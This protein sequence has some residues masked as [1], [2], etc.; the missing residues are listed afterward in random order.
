M[1]QDSHGDNLTSISHNP[2]WGC[3]PPSLVLMTSELGTWPLQ[4]ATAAYC[5]P[6]SSHV[7]SVLLGQ[8]STTPA[9]KEKLVLSE[10][11]LGC[12]VHA[13]VV[14]TRAQQS[15]AWLDTCSTCPHSLATSLPC[16]ESKLVSV[17]WTLSS[18]SVRSWA[19][20]EKQWSLTPSGRSAWIC[21]RL[22]Y[23]GHPTREPL[24]FVPSSQSKQI[25]SWEIADHHWVILIMRPEVRHW[26]TGNP[27][28]FYSTPF[29]LAF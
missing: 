27:G 19:S 13:W 11:K 12:S 22:C 25:Q 4:P 15:A 14:N 29:L 10:A 20:K 28:R 7:S 2:G 5:L 3:V 9:L 18:S 16:P 26:H 21:W 1:W 6:S 8:Q 17:K 23:T 24:S